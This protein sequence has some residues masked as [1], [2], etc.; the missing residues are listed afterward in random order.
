M[1]FEAINIFLSSTF[2]NKMIVNRDKFRNEITAKLNAIAGQAN[3]LVYFKDFELGIPDDTKPL[4]VVEV[5]LDAISSSNYFIG[6]IGEN[7]GTSVKEFLNTKDI[8]KS[9]YFKVI[10]FAIS[11]DM[12]VLELEFFYALNQNINS[13]YFFDSQSSNYRIVK[14]LLKYNQNIKGFSNTEM[15]INDFIKVF[16]SDFNYKYDNVFRESIQERNTN[17]IAANKLRYYVSDEN[18][19]KSIN[20]Y[21]N[22]HSNKAFLIY[23]KSGWGKSTLLF[24]WINSDEEKILSAYQEYYY[25]PEHY[26]AYLE[27][28]LY[29]VLCDIDNKNN[30]NYAYNYDSLSSEIQKVEYF[31]TIISDLSFKCIFIFDGLD[32]LLSRN[33]INPLA[34][35]PQRINEYTKI[36]I[37]SSIFPNKSNLIIYE[38]DHFDY[39]NLIK[40]FFTKEGKILIYEK[41]KKIFSA[42][43]DKEVSPLFIRLLLSEICIT[44]K[45]DNIES[46]LDSYLLQFNKTKNPYISYV[47]RLNMYFKDGEK[48][49]F[50]DILVYLFISKNGLAESDL[51]KLIESNK[52]KDILN[53]VY[54]ELQKNDIE[55]YILL[56]KHLKDSVSYLYI[57]KID[58]KYYVNKLSDLVSDKIYSNSSD[59]DIYD[60]LEEYLNVLES[61]DDCECE[62]IDLFSHC[63]IIANLWYHNRQLVM[64][65]FSSIKNRSELINGWKK[66]IENDNESNAPYFIAHLLSEFAMYED[67]VWFSSNGL[68]RFLSHPN[69][70]DDKDLATEYNN[71]ALYMTYANKEEYFSLIEVYL[72][73]AYDIRKKNNSDVCSF[74]ESCNNLS[75]FYEDF[76]IAEARKYLNEELSKINNNPSVNLDILSKAYI[77]NASLL[78]AEKEYKKAHDYNKR[79]Y[80]IYK[81]IYSE[82]S[83]ECSKIVISDSYIY[84]LE[85]DYLKIIDSLPSVIDIYESKGI[86][87]DDLIIAY[88]NLANAYYQTNTLCKN[89]IDTYKN[90]YRLL[91]KLNND[92][93]KDI[94]NNLLQTATEY[95][96]KLE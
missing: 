61:K 28:F 33:G 23:A 11:N 67:A 13:Y 96:I 55:K 49:P 21:I 20:N 54:F 47:E 9:K 79:A 17:I 22:G 40:N 14:Q 62:L 83:F 73:K 36:I 90:Y 64:R 77:Q 52:I 16:R 76:D 86:E 63:D 34:L 30:T 88:N 56:N 89:A 31:K 10:D 74:C 45:Y 78:T 59:S 38:L 71:L 60:N 15:L 6:L 43:I 50:R 39:L 27:D 41:Y 32:K 51:S 95:N 4:D 12:T 94:L 29:S 75:N 68:K 69:I 82:K 81:S 26:Y 87:N 35:I 19:I 66:Y 65:A 5:C 3:V 91:L 37:T 46:V 1:N 85:K 8:S 70:V 42:R 25:F 57:N 24:D 80:E 48:E 72:K 84:T 44:A 7:N 18:A 93:Y 92:K 2:D 53:V 58:L